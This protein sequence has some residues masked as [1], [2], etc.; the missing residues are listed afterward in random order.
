MKKSVIALTLLALL[1]VSACSTAAPSATVT[2]TKVVIIEPSPTNTLTASPVPPTETPT[3]TLVPSPTPTPPPADYGPDDFPSNV[4]PL[5]GLPVSDPTK[6]ERLPMGIKIQIF[7][8]GQRPTWSISLA[9]IVYDYYQNSGLTRL[10]AIYYGNDSEQVGPIRSARLFD[11]HIVRL[12]NMIFAFGGAFRPILNQLLNNTYYNRLVLEGSNLCPVMCRVDPDGYNYLVA[13]TKELNPYVA[14]KGVDTSRPNLNGMTFQLLPPEG[15]Q[16]G[17]SLS[18][19]YS[20]SSYIRWDYDPVNGKY[21]RFQD[22]QEAGNEE[23]EQY[24]PFTDRD[25]GQQVSAANVVV[26][27]T[28]HQLAFGT[29]YGM[30]EIIDIQLSGTGQAIIFRDGQAY[31]VTWN[32]PPTDTPLYLTD[33]EGNAFPFKQG[34]TWFQVIGQN[35]SV[36]QREDGSWRFENRLP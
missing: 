21:L 22:T 14:G 13:N 2:P 15:G 9:D 4:N 7:P 35:S 36:E 20:I 34:N 31:E 3:P 1:V 12:Y 6:L 29:R 30:K 32:R 23:E 5:T 16:S 18:V 11:D 19:R 8:R 28:P 17:E 10:N 33:A 24:A 26:I 25:D 27:I